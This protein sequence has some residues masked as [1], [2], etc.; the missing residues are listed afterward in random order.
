MIGFLAE[1]N[2]GMG[3]QRL[4]RPPWKYEPTPIKSH[5]TS[6]FQRHHVCLGF[7]LASQLVPYADHI[8]NLAALLPCAPERVLI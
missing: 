3:L 1:W 8:P 4:H 5:I 2:P 7:S 6:P